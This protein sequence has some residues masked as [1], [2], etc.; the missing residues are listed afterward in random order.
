[1][2][3]S[4]PATD[5][6][7]L[8]STLYRHGLLLLVLLLSVAQVNAEVSPSFDCDK[9]KTQVERLIC[10]SP[11]LSRLDVMLDGAYR[12]AL[13]ASPAPDKLREEQ[14]AWLKS[15]NY[16]KDIKCLEMDYRDRLEALYLSD[17]PEHAA[18]RGAL[19]GYGETRRAIPNVIDI[20]RKADTIEAREYS[21][22]KNA[23]VCD[24]LVE[25]VRT[26]GD[27]KVVQ[28]EVDNARFDDPRLQPYLRD[29]DKARK[30]YGSTQV[31]RS[32]GGMKIM[33]DSGRVNTPYD[34]YAVWEL[35]ACGGGCFMLYQGPDHINV[36]RSVPI[37]VEQGPYWGSGG[38][39]FRIFKAEGCEQRAVRG[40]PH[41][42]AR[43]SAPPL[44]RQ[45]ELLLFKGERYL[46]TIG[47]LAQPGGK[48]YIT[49]TI[50]GINSDGRFG[51]TCLFNVTA[52]REQ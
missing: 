33:A 27:F 12:S 23:P 52:G 21:T 36:E 40:A 45:S 4:N 48:S 25:A 19:E 31:P 29:C 14:R 7:H 10:E 11:T 20:L 16:C 3:K 26:D 43:G 13:A 39:T 51:T 6:K 15:R 34:D 28:P 22:I 35:P 32:I 18:S 47:D 37:Y 5:N 49:S 41:S 46:A 17:G 9:A 44:I 8:I 2:L 42:G 30:R 1:M 38:G 24:A 50:S